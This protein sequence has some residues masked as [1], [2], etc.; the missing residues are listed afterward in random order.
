MSQGTASWRAPDELPGP[1][2]KFAQASDSL[3]SRHSAQ[4]YLNLSATA[5][6][7]INRPSFSA[8][9]M[10]VS[11]K[12]ARASR[13]RCWKVGFLM[14]ASTDRP[15]NIRAQPPVGSTWLV[16]EA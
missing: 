4:T 1:D 5:R 7:W 6:A 10:T 16:P 9:V 11:F 2:W 13:D 14:N 3:F 8:R 15:E 12:L